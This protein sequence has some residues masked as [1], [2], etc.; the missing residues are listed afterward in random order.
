MNV[1]NLETQE[2]VGV[3][4]AFETELDPLYVGMPDFLP[5][6]ALDQEV[7]KLPG[8]TDFKLGVRHFN[9]EPYVVAY[10][11]VEKH[12]DHELL[13]A[14]VEKAFDEVD[15]AEKGATS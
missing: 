4:Y 7:S 5:A 14:D 9:G 8:V 10:I 1:I 13:W 11:T 12:M 15:A 6:K 2:C 3:Q